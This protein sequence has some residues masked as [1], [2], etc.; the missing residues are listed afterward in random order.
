MLFSTCKI[1]IK[2]EEN[3]THKIEHQRLAWF[4]FSLS[5]KEKV[6]RGGSHALVGAVVCRYEIVSPCECHRSVHFIVPGVDST[7]HHPTSAWD[8]DDIRI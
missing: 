3:T 8:S 6:I 5:K 1:L 7:P 2:F 4:L